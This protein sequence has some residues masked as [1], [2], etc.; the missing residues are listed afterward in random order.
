MGKS[1]NGYML[2]LLRHVCNSGEIREYSGVFD[3]LF[4]T[5]FEWVVPLDENCSVNAE[6]LREDYLSSSRFAYEEDIPEMNATV[7]EVMVKIAVQMETE[8]M[9]NDQYGDRTGQ[10][11]WGMMD[12][13]GLSNYPDRRFNADKVDRILE[14]FMHREYSFDGKGGL[15]TVKRPKND[16]RKEEIWSQAMQYMTQFGEKNG[17]I[18]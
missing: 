11:F 5:E 16:L 13:L 17:E 10:W 4:N 2:W 8:I 18:W 1:K 12:S 3:I 7:L 15:F 9:V 14:I 6:Q